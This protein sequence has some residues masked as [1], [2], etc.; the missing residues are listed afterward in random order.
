MAGCFTANGIITVQQNTN[1]VKFIDVWSPN[2]IEYTQLSAGLA[3]SLGL[4]SVLL[5]VSIALRIFKKTLG[6]AGKLIILLV[7]H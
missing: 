1:L 3:I 6:P 5:V 2:V 4:L 7:S